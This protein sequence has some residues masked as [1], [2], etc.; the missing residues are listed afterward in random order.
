MPTKGIVKIRV[1]ISSPARPKLELVSIRKSE[2]SGWSYQ[3]SAVSLFNCN[4][5]ILLMA[6]RPAV[7]ALIALI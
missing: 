1:K 5:C 6:E 4:T 7:A 2:I 3:Q